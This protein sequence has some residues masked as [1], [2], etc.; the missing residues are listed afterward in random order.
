[1]SDFS[2][3]INSVS[4]SDLIKNYEKKRRSEIAENNEKNLS[5]EAQK[6]Y[7]AYYAKMASEHVGFENFSKE[8]Q[9]GFKNHIVEMYNKISGE[10]KQGDFLEEM[11][12]SAKFIEDRH[13]EVGIGKSEAS[14]GGGEKRDRTVGKNFCYR[15]EDERPEGYEKSGGASLTTDNGENVPVWE[16]GT[17]NKNGEDILVV[18]VFD[19]MHRGNEY[20]D[21]K[22]F[23]EKFDEVYD[24]DRE[25]W[26]KG[27]IILD[28]RGNRGGEDKPID[29]V[30]KR[31]YGNLVNTY[32][33]CEV[34]DS[35]LGYY[36]YQQ[37]GSVKN[38]KKS[39]L[40]V[41][42]RKYFSGT[43]KAMF[44]ETGV[45]YT[46]NE[47]KGYKGKI[48]VLTCARVG[49]SAES[50][51]TSFYHHPNVRYI[52]ENTA[53]MQQYT[54]GTFATP[55]GGEMRVGWGKLTY[56]DKEGENIEVKGH[57]P[58]VNC[59]GYDAFDVALVIPGD[60]GRVVGFRE[61]NEEV[62]GK[63]VVAE[64]NPKEKSDPRKAYY[65]DYTFPAMKKLEE[66]NRQETPTM[67]PEQRAN[68][69]KNAGSRV[70]E[71][72]GI[73]DN[74]GEEQ[75]VKEKGNV[76]RKTSARVDMSGFEKSMG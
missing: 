7:L 35:P 38:A 49:S 57:K 66:E 27:R 55:W 64:Y 39:G 16:I 40:E 76:T 15:T 44:D 33:R 65:T 68:E 28:V 70:R 73:K 53:G 5:V 69:A 3:I 17:L 67:T 48:D 24:K 8:N 18:S 26:D 60:Y 6:F 12:E 37:H 45:Y 42:E 23:I 56:W 1:M 34:K 52:G 50:A 63:E 62:K 10:R 59:K 4:F 41:P 36:L 47:E 51:Y 31:T 46:F 71:M 58:D 20:E 30:A 61:L 25:K 2:E 14:R 9:E 19:M 21:W 32:K 22:D 75:S 43:S 72:L 13:F 11:G 74:K 29:H 54:Q